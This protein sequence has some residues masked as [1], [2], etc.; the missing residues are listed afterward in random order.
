MSDKKRNRVLTTLQLE[1]PDKIPIHNLGFE[2]TG[3]AYQYFI[4]TDDIDNYVTF[5]SMGDLTEIKFW[6][7]DINGMDPFPKTKNILVKRPEEFPDSLLGLHGKLRKTSKNY[8][9][10]MDYTWYSGPYFTSEERIREFWNAYGKPSTWVADLSK[11]KKQTWENY[12]KE[13]ED[14]VYP[15]AT[16]PIAMFEALFEGIGAAKLAY[17]F[18]KKPQ[19]IHEIMKEYTYVNMEILKALTDVGV[20]IIFLFDDL[21]Q[22]E[23]SLLSQKHFREFILPYYKE[24]YQAA[25]KRGAFFVQHSCGYID[26]LLP[27]MVDAGLSCIQALEPAAGVNLAQ[28][29]LDLGDR[30]AFMGGMDSSATLNFGTPQEVEEDVKKC[31]LAAG[32]GG[33][34]FAGPSH[35]IMDVPWENVM[36]MRA[37]LQ[38]Y[39]NYPLNY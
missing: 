5:K 7:L 22:K 9:T 18:R 37:A 27:D 17:F 38:K 11:Y 32:K 28:V 2:R 24:L 30:V 23:R 29:K 19:L 21:G 20:D 6:D 39:R 13:L 16:L 26:D 31:I 10:G 33:G 12:T 25:K 34:Y 35:N 3:T 14:I 4:E 36:A 8:K 15:M 1:E